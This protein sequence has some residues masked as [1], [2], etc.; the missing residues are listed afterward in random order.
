MHCWADSWKRAKYKWNS[1]VG[2]V[3]ERGP[4][5]LISGWYVQFTKHIPSFSWDHLILSKNSKKRKLIDLR[6]KPQIRLFVPLCGTCAAPTIEQRVTFD[7][8]SKCRFGFAQ[9]LPFW[10]VKVTMTQWVKPT[11]NFWTFLFN[12]FSV[13]IQNGAQ[14]IFNV[15]EWV[16]T[17]NS[18][19]VGDAGYAF[20]WG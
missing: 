4:V 17:E 2:T 20:R 10:L 16:P 11:T 6:F 12:Q 14:P 7:G 19:R 5:G 15:P 1:S 13:W 18:F 9:T 3:S 8:Q